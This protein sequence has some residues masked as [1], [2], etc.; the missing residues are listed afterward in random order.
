MNYEYENGYS[1]GLRDG[2]KYFNVHL[3]QSDYDDLAE[4]TRREI[5]EDIKLKLANEML[6]M[7]KDYNDII[8]GFIRRHAYQLQNRHNLYEAQFYDDAV[9]PY[10]FVRKDR[11]L[12][13]VEPPK[14]VAKPEWK[15]EELPQSIQ[16]A[17]YQTV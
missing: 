11:T 9:F 13:K 17:I 8:D 3:F 4:M 14:V 6:N 15:S 5:Y 10:E 16:D 7:F 12:K 2:S 1:K